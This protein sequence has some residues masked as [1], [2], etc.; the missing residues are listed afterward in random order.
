VRNA[1]ESFAE[2]RERDVRTAT[3]FLFWVVRGQPTEP[4][5]AALWCTFHTA[6]LALFPVVLGHV[7]QVLVDGAPG[8]LVAAGFTVLGVGAAIAV[9]KVMVHRYTTLIWVSVSARLQ[10]L[11]ARH[12]TELGAVLARRLATGEVVKVSAGDTA[13][14]ATLADSLGQGAASVLVSLAVVGYL[15]TYEP[16]I[17]LLAVGGL[18]VIAL[19][20]FPMLAAAARRAD[21][22]RTRSGWASELASDTVAGL[23][24]LRG[25]GGE[26]LFLDRYRRASQEVRVAAVRSARA[27]GLIEA[28]QVTLS[29]LLLVAMIWYGAVLARGGRITVGELVAIYGA[30]TFLMAQLTLIRQT[31]SLFASTLPAASRVARLAR[32]RRDTSGAAGGGVSTSPWGDLTD[33]VSGLVAPQG[34]LTA[35]VCGSSDAGERLVARLAANA[36]ADPAAM[37]VQDKDPFLFSGT[38]AELLTVPGSGRVA[39]AAALRAAQ[40]ADVLTSLAVASESANAMDAIVV[41][42]GRALSGGQRQRLALARSLVADPDI[43]VLDEPTSAV[44]AHTEARIAAS[45][46]RLRADRTTVVFTSS[47]LLLDCADVVAFVPDEQV[48]AVG[49]HRDLARSVPAYRAVTRR[50]GDS[51]LGERISG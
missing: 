44:D 1:D 50:G 43:L 7:V 11:V 41:G 27:A 17:A 46:R 26:A 47:P 39:A 32:Q 10:R 40:C 8:R 3:R 34:R 31:A 5:I 38:V 25:I 30:T 23:R 12:V 37:V 9:G 13:W 21:V 22:E 49:S 28:I 16:T 18:G 42:R 4:A 15:V 2:L 14:I 20:S 35:V 6:G 51:P 29:G 36:G 19:L 33:S 24:I 45:V 48:V